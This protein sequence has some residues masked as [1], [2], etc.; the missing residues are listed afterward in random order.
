MPDNNRT[1]LT[2]LRFCIC[3]ELVHLILWF[4]PSKTPEGLQWLIW[5]RQ[6]PRKGVK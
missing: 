6:I 5:L 3:V 1:I 2:E 4:L